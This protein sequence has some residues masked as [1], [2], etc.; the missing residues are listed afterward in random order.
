MQIVDAD[1]ILRYL[2]KDI[3][4][5]HTKA[6]QI[7]DNKQIHIPFEVIAEVFYVFEKIYEVPRSEIKEALST[8]LNYPNISTLNINILNEALKIYEKQKIDFVDSLL[9]SYNHI[10]KD[11]IY[12]FDKKLNKLLLGQ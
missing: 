8:L 2:L 10:Q 7:I 12:S 1:I 9:V 6:V 11:T 5:L 4:E 3:E